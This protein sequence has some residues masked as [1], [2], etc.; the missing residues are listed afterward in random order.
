VFQVLLPMFA[1]AVDIVAVYGL[2]FLDPLRIGL[3]WL[4]FLGVQFVAARYAFALDKERPGPLWALPLQQVVYRQLMYLVVL[5]SV[6][7][8]L[9]GVRLRWHKL[10]RTGQLDAAPVA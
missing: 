9:Y 2:I 6:A 3:A 10:R 4:A 7:S 1:P 8:A 5:Q